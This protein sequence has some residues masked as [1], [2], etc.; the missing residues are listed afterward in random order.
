MCYSV[1][2]VQGQGKAQLFE[3]NNNFVGT[4]GRLFSIRGCIC[5]DFWTILFYN[6]GAGLDLHPDQCVNA[7]LKLYHIPVKK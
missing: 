2:F 7:I 1:V 5:D 6:K 4:Y 3:R